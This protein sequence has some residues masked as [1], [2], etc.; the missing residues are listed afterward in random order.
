MNCRKWFLFLLTLILLIPAFG[1]SASAAEQPSFCYELSVD[2]KDTVEVNPGDVITVTLYLYRED[3]DEV[4]TM[5]A[6]QDEI[7]YDVEF[8]D[9]VEGSTLL[10]AGIQ[11][12]DIALVDHYREFYMNY[13]SLDGGI[14]W[15]AKMRIGSFQLKV[16][17]SSGVST[18]TNQDFLVSFFDGSTSY[19]C[20]AN[21]L[22]VILS[23]NCIIKFE[24]NGGT[25]IDP[26]MGIYGETIGRPKDP[27]REGKHIVGWYKDI[28]LMDEWNFETDTVRGNMTLYAKWENGDPV[29]GGDICIICGSDRNGIFGICWLCLLLIIL[30]ILAVLYAIRRNRKKQIKGEDL[31]DKAYDNL[32]EIQDTII[33]KGT[34]SN[35]CDS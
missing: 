6:M 29:A 9:L 34:E 28:D 19:K 5:Y 20:D 1:V 18:I 21:E 27:I 2:G 35:E 12:T 7:R 16:I 14:Q 23:T 3:K 13:V 8:F 11:S 32:G 26:I 17:G 4:Y 22:T 31:K 30:L 33:K 15:P 25:P 24:T 10:S